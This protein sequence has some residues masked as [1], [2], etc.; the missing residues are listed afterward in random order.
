M[1]PEQ[2]QLEGTLM[3][4][5]ILAAVVFCVTLVRLA[6]AEPAGQPDRIEVAGGAVLTGRISGVEAGRLALFT[7]YAGTL[8]VE[9]D[10]VERVELGSPRPL[11]LPERL[12]AA[13]PA[14]TESIAPPQ[15]AAPPLQPETPQ[16][17]PAPKWSVEGGFNLS[18]RSGNSEKFDLA[19]TLDAELERTFDRTNLFSRYAYGTNRRARSAN[20]IIV[21]GRYT[22]FLFNRTGLFFR[23]ELEKDEF[24]RIR[25]RSLSAFGVT[26]QFRN[27]EELRIE[28]RTGL[29]FRYEDYEDDGEDQFWGIDL[30]VDINWEIRKWARFKG[31]Y[32]LQPSVRDTQG[33][34]FEQDSGLNLAIGEETPWKLRLGFSSTFNSE[35]DPGRESLD[36][37]YYARLI[38]TWY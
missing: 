17:P 6:G 36:T 14:A 26:R 32:T 28:G 7:D 8:Q 11:N 33:F 23:Q 5:L 31:A 12:L 35:P 1:S 15:A 38:A 16:A 25:A 10:K 18:G 21:G 19:V 34:I 9:L 22:N 2:A 29:S 20:E 4:R 37:R 27:S 13:A 30:G 24:E 3:K